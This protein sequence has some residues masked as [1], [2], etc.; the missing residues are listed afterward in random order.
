MGGFLPLIGFIGFIFSL[1][2]LVMRFIKRKSKKK[3]VI[4]LIVTFV[5]FIIGVALTPI[6]ITEADYDPNIT[7]V[8]IL[9]DDL[10]TIKGSSIGLY[11]YESALGGNITIPRILVS[12]ININ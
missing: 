1:V 4:S 8:R 9:E 6:S 2:W 10:V 11:T 7:N 12:E 5:L 3:I